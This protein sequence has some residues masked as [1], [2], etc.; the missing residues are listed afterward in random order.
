[1]IS[2]ER[3]RELL[4][5]DAETGELRWRERR[6]GGVPWAVAGRIHRLGYRAI[7]LDGKMYV[8]HRLAWLYVHG[9][10]PAHQLDH[11]NRVKDDNRIENLR[12]CNNSQN[13][14]NRSHFRNNKCGLKGVSPATKGRWRAQIQVRGRYIHIGYFK[15]PQEA[16]VAYRAAALHH[17]GEFAMTNETTS[18]HH[19]Q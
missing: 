15:T 9:E 2:A 13:L 7:Q 4:S 10:W 12:Q 17:F 5:Y 16:S 18:T 3:L 6:G 1:M 8:A 14:A 19:H 11:I